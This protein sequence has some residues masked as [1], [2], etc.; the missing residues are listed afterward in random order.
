MKITNEMIPLIEK[1]LGFTLY[2]WQKNYL[3]GEPHEIPPGRAVGK[4][5]A[6]IVKFLLTSKEPIKLEFIGRYQDY[7][8]SHYKHWFKGEVKYIHDKLTDVGLTTQLVTMNKPKQSISIAVDADTEK[9]QLK[10][11]AIAKHAEQLANELDA[12]D[13]AWQCECGSF[14][15]VDL[16]HDNTVVERTCSECNERYAYPN[17]D[18]LPTRLEGSE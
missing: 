6:Y 15:Y 12:I 3:L 11:R 4:T 16:Y 7:V 8:G 10:L 9:L 5:V 1:A 17:N 2:D 13:N 18:D 14:A